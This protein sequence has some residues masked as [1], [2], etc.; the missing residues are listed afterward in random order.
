MYNT[1]HNTFKMKQWFL[2]SRWSSIGLSLPQAANFETTKKKRKQ[3]ISLLTINIRTQVCATF[4][5][6]LLIYNVLV[7]FLQLYL[8][9]DYFFYNCLVISS[10][11]G[12]KQKKTYLLLGFSISVELAELRAETSLKET[13]I[14]HCLVCR[15]LIKSFITTTKYT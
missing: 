5:R 15:R 7:L 9:A 8:C 3:E 10:E 6:F 1:G 13:V 2:F 14:L 11:N 12:V 4:T